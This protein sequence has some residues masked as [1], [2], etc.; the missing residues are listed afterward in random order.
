MNSLVRIVLV[1]QIVVKCKGLPVF[2]IQVLLV[3]V[4]VALRVLVLLLMAILVL[5]LRIDVRSS[6]LRG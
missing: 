5:E 2:R 6:L 4:K 1:D 3:N